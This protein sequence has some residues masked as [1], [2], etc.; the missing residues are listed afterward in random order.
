MN[1]TENTVRK[2][3]RKQILKEFSLKD[4]LQKTL[5]N[6]SNL[7][8]KIENVK[9][10]L[11]DAAFKKIYDSSIKDIKS[12]NDFR[13]WVNT[14][15]S[16]QE[17]K[18]ALSDA[19]LSG[20]FDKNITNPKFAKNKFVEAVFKEFGKEYIIEKIKSE[21]RN[22]KVSRISKVNIEK[23][24][25]NKDPYPASPKNGLPEKYLKG[26]LGG[27]NKDEAKIAVAFGIE[28][29]K[30]YT[31]VAG[32]GNK[33]K[34]KNLKE[35]KLLNE[36]M[37]SP[38]EVSLTDIMK[39]VTSDRNNFEKINNKLSKKASSQFKELE[40]KATKGIEITPEMKKQF[41]KDYARGKFPGGQ[42]LKPMKDLRP[43]E[44]L[45][46]MLKSS[47]GFVPQV[48]D[49]HKKRSRRYGKMGE[50]KRYKD[51]YGGLGKKGAGNP[52]IGYGHLIYGGV[53]FRDE[54]KRFE[55][56]LVGG[57][58]KMTKAEAEDL[59]EEDL[60]NHSPKGEMYKK[61]SKGKDLPDDFPLTQNMFDALIHWTFNA[62]VINLRKSGIIDALL[63]KNYIKAAKL[64]RTK[65][66][67]GA[68]NDLSGRRKKESKMFLSGFQ[69][70]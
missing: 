42:K 13:N 54:R 37:K 59:F 29:G 57:G 30:V 40:K 64:I 46:V 65:Y 36:R 25:V 7:T 48:Y 49:D 44:F 10:D 15:K 26:I 43:S 31:R 34:V 68:G 12:S 14:N 18:K 19:G 17:I 27:D 24:A 51:V 61:H 41:K 38:N 47:E 67:G 23:F 6:V 20:S 33:F 53:P 1:I 35:S 3:I 58:K 9:N 56:Y 52:T 28:T 60:I 32:S 39:A 8:S 55:D 50:L 45:K 22:A 69:G 16:Q 4:A 62:G 66:T 2:I 11:S 70:S 5:P 63:D 21:S